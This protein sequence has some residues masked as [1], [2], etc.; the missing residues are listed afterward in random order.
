MSRERPTFIQPDWS[1]EAIAQRAQDG[2][3][4]S[5]DAEKLQEHVHK[6]LKALRKIRQRA[7]DN[8]M[9]REVVKSNSF[10]FHEIMVEARDAIESV[11]SDRDPVQ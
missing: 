9:G 10:H 11:V 7:D 4:Y 6:L 1:I 3:S 8:L 5:A 2:L